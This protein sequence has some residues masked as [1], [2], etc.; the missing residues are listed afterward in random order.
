M[1]GGKKTEKKH[2]KDP[3]DVWF[4]EN[5]KAEAGLTKLPHR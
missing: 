2:M 5:Y 4:I 1:E 3:A